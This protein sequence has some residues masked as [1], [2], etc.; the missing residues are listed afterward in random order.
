MELVAGYESDEEEK[1]VKSAPQ[2]ELATPAPNTAAGASNGDTGLGAGADAGR[3]KQKK[4][5]R[6]APAADPETGVN[7]EKARAALAAGTLPSLADLLKKPPT[8]SFISTDV[9]ALAP[10]WLLPSLL[11]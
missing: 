2:P 11:P 1:P 4:R 6:A 10:V 7:V 3:K 8:K 5:D 9:R